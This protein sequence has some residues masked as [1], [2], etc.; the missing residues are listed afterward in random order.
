MTNLPLTEAPLR[1]PTLALV[2][3]ERPSFRER[4]ELLLEAGR[5]LDDPPDLPAAL[6]ALA[7]FLAGRL[8][9]VCLIDLVVSGGIV[10][11]AVAH[12]APERSIDALELRRRHPPRADDCA[13]VTEVLRTG[14]AELHAELPREAPMLHAFHAME[15]R[16]AM[17]AP[18]Y[19]PGHVVGAITV[20]CAA[21]RRFDGADLRVLEELGARAGLLAAAFAARE[22]RPPR[23]ERDRD[24]LLAL[25]KQARAAAE[26]AVHRISTLQ[27]VTAALSEAVTL[28]QV[29]D[30]IVRESL[31][32]LGAR[33]GVV[34][35]LDAAEETLGLVSQRGMTPA[36]ETAA[37]RLPLSG[38]QNLVTT[39]VRTGNPVWIVGREQVRATCPALARWLVDEREPAALGAIPLA[40][41]GRVAGVLGLAFDAAEDVSDDDR[42]FALVLMR[43]CAQAIDRARL[44]EAERRSN[45]R[46]TL[47]AR[48][49]E[50]LARSIDYEA[51]LDA[52]ARFALP[53]LGDYAFFDVSDGT[54]A[55]RIARAH[56]G[57]GLDAKLAGLG[58]RTAPWPVDD[59]PEP[60]GVRLPAAPGPRLCS[61][62]DDAALQR[63]AAE[64]GDLQA[65][66]RLHLSSL[67]TVPLTARAETLGT[68]TLAFGP[69][70]RRHTAADLQIAAELAHRAAIA[71]ENALLH[72][73]MREAMERAQDANRSSELASRTKDEF[74]GVVS[75]ELRTPLNAVLGWS[76]LLRGPCA[77]DPAVLAKGLR[78]IDRNARAQAKLIEDILDVSRIITGKLR[79]ELRPLELESVIRAAL[80]VVRPA[81]EAK[82]VEIVS[83]VGAGASVSGDPDRL[84]QVVWNLLCNAVKFTPEGGRVELTLT[85]EGTAAVIAVR[86]TGRGIEPEVLP[87]VF[88]RFWQADSSPTRRHGGLGL[89]LAIARHLVELHGGSVRADSH[90]LGQGATFTVLLPAREETSSDG[91]PG[92]RI[93]RDSYPTAGCT[94]LDGLRVLVVD[95]EPDARELVG[96][97][98]AQAG[99]AVT[100]A[101]SSAEAWRA[102]EGPVPDVLVSDIGMPGED[103]HALV[104]RV[105]A[106]PRLCR[107]PAVALTAYAGVEDARRAVRAGFHTHMPKPAEP[108]V[109]TAVV[110]SLAGRVT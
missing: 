36:G 32:S 57:P 61:D 19:A 110:A 9:D 78:V 48:A 67:I 35:L 25:E 5:I 44:Y 14:R 62:V 104:R 58:N 66:R 52:V 63:L 80:E 45:Q 96:T 3:T 51:T 92:A 55:R 31:T 13:G 46:L 54:G 38:E 99:A 21:E 27:T 86:D 24:R 85:R 47:L 49:G 29:A 91:E 105:R 60:P 81:A 72:R 107:L 33:V 82:D 37:A 23:P 79:L 20:L 64:P 30:L 90:G 2:A 74:L 18:L 40:V 8:G 98:L 88:E 93:T 101:G 34:Y 16:A 68:L 22:T 12:A 75:H 108:T 106:S 41:S 73:A 50:I 6:R 94:R 65:L 53:A 28:A 56:G 59:Y 11:V 15:A 69:S 4:F 102:L 97:M 17:V 76:Q 100:V 71:L 109:L 70:G 83:L 42:V 95:D 43:H 1:A 84:Q 7:R 103:G 10:A 77:S 26:V 87:H 89:G 39:A